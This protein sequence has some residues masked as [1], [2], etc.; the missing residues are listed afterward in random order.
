MTS[1]YATARNGLRL[2]IVYGFGVALLCSN[3]YVVGQFAN[4]NKQ[5]ETVKA[6][7]EGTRTELKDLK[8]AAATSTKAAGRTLSA[9]REELQAARNQAASAV[10]EV[11]AGATRRAEELS[12]ELGR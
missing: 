7:L 1:G 2:A 3:L 10:G 5:L 12:S 9:I 11:K 4:V 6:D 8:N